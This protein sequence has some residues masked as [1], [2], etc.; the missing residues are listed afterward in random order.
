VRKIV[1]SQSVY[2]PWVGMLEQV[3]L[4]D[5]FVHYDDVQFSK[6]SFT[7]RVQ[8]KTEHGRAWMTVPLCDHRLG[9][10]I[11]EIRPD[12]RRDW[13]GQ[14]R[15]MLA[16]AYENAP[17]RGDMLALVDKVF[18]HP[19]GTLADLARASGL[20]LA[21]Y[22][23]LCSDRRFVDSRDLGVAGSSSQRVHDIVKALEGD[24]Y[25]TGHGASRYLDHELFERS[26]IAVRYMQYLCAPYSQL[27]GPF[28]PYV[29]ALDLVANCGREGIHVIR[30]QSVDW[31][32]FTN[33]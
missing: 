31:R 14:H 15:A 16:R 9:Q 23:G 32:I 6:G 20:A 10:L 8:V 2:F 3:R 24:T 7:N 4:A 19:A 28:N 33:A 21:E 11:D 17:Y 5:T 18:E 1:I 30:S 22:F 26:G 29:T 27:H 13:R 25:I 12:D